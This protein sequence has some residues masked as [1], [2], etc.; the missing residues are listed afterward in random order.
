MIVTNTTMKQAIWE[1]LTSDP[2]ALDLDYRIDERPADLFALRAAKGE[3]P[4][5]VASL[6]CLLVE[7][8]TGVLESN[9]T[10]VARFLH[11]ALPLCDSLAAVECKSALK[12]ILLLD[13]PSDWDGNLSEIQEL[14]SR[15]LVGIQKEDADFRFWVDIAEKANSCLPYALN[16]AVEIDLDKGMDLVC[17]AH[18]RCAH[19]KTTDT[20]D[21][22][23]VF[24]LA[25][26]RYGEK[27]VQRS[28]DRI[29]ARYGE[30]ADK[31]QE[32]LPFAVGKRHGLSHRGKKDLHER[33]KY[34][35]ESDF[36]V[37]LLGAIQ[38][39]LHEARKLDE[40]DSR[41]AIRAIEEILNRTRMRLSASDLFTTIVDEDVDREQRAPAKALSA[42]A[43][44]NEKKPG[45]KST[46][47]PSGK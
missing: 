37:V 13:N 39:S 35:V 2:D 24:A 6:R 30:E 31:L 28:W 27:E 36:K 10:E 29:R 5:I 19:E 14:A 22:A 7:I 46:K 41:V 16:A 20:V 45:K 8:I 12:Q 38:E 3:R 47:Q 33:G 1:R 40:G 42:G 15:A 4:E 44:Q 25:V 18:I 26:D 21:W 23:V 43:K 17:N 32:H 9:S 34:H 11:N